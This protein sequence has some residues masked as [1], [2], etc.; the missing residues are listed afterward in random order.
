M[1]CLDVMVLAMVGLLPVVVKPSAD[2]DAVRDD[3]SFN[4]GAPWSFL[5]VPRDDGE[6]DYC[7]HGVRFGY[8]WRDH[9]WVEG[10]YTSFDGHG[11]TLVLG[12]PRLGV[13]TRWLGGFIK[14]QPGMIHGVEGE[15]SSDPDGVRFVLSAGGVA[16]AGYSSN[17]FF[18]LDFGYL[19]IW[20]GDATV[21]RRSP[22]R[23]RFRPGTSAYP[24]W[25]FGIGVRF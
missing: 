24:H 19:I 18:R 25:S 10:E 13:R 2:A 23:S 1:T 15:P 14:L 4:L 20:Y 6:G 11:Q 8:S 3:A 22:I 21:G 5:E 7:G 12:G 17:A 9:L 16:E